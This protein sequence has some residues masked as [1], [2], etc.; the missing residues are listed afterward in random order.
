[1]D[2]QLRDR[3][4]SLVGEAKNRIENRSTSSFDTTAG[5]QPGDRFL[6]P[7]GPDT[8][9][10]WVAILPNKDDASLWYV[11]AA[12]Q[13]SFV[14]SAD[15]VVEGGADIS[16]FVLR[17]GHG[18]WVKEFEL[19]PDFYLGRVK[20]SFVDHAKEKLQGMVQGQLASTKESEFTDDAPAYVEW[21]EEISSVIESIERRIQSEK[22]TLKFRDAQSD[23]QSLV[24]YDFAAD[25]SALAASS[26]VSF[27]MVAESSEET[28]LVY[29]DV[30][31]GS[32][33]IQR[34][35]SGLLLQYYP[36]GDEEPDQIMLVNG[37]TFDGSWGS[38]PEHGPY[39][40][41]H[42]ISFVETGVEVVFGSGKTI[43][44]ED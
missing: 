15:V 21:S 18:L 25:H 20:E 10:T 6:M 23:W 3:F 30:L 28:P 16:D 22:V 44:I 34:D 31:P 11:V 4:E 36:I 8:P 41:S 2:K 32:I 19:I 17:C 42:R 37:G 35:Y 27:G 26:G 12:D 7:D 1:M 29:N 43:R 9:L 33:V 24:E 14:G 13:F 5:V 40:L 38:K 39:L